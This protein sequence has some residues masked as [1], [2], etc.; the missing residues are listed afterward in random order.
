L[1]DFIFT[2]GEA[3]VY[4]VP[5]CSAALRSEDELAARH[6][7]VGLEIGGRLASF[8][9][10]P[11]TAGQNLRPTCLVNEIDRTAFEGKFSFAC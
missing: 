10:E 5:I 4:S 11:E 1:D 6:Q 2:D 8:R 3:D 7:L 9:H